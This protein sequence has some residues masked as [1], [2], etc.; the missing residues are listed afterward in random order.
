MS[1]DNIPNEPS[2]EEI[3]RNRTTAHIV[4]LNGLFSIIDTPRLEEFAQQFANTFPKNLDIQML[5]EP[6]DNIKTHREELRAEIRENLDSGDTNHIEYTAR[7]V[8]IL[9]ILKDKTDKENYIKFIKGLIGKSIDVLVSLQS[10]L[11]DNPQ[12]AMECLG[13]T[14]HQVTSSTGDFMLRDSDMVIQVI[15]SNA[16]LRK[17]V[18]ALCNAII[19]TSNYDEPLYNDPKFTQDL[20]FLME[21]ITYLIG[22]SCDDLFPNL[23]YGYSSNK[24]LHAFGEV[25]DES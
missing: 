17:D 6:K 2:L 20:K 15:Q 13:R 21:L 19:P 18:F 22:F 3:I 25:P 16:E 10:C 4:T 23:I 12:L 9:I 24:L 1:S 14:N 11:K 7:L 5:L 8:E